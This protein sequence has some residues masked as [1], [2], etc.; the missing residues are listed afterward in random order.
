MAILCPT[1][2]FGI[3]FTGLC[4]TTLGFEHAGLFYTISAISM[5]AIRLA[6]KSFMDT[7]PVIKTYAVAVACALVEVW[8]AFGCSHGGGPLFLASGIIY[9]LALGIAMP[10]TKSVAIK[11]TP[12]ECWGA[13]SALFLLMNDLGIGVPSSLRGAFNDIWGFQAGTLCLVACQVSSFIAARILF[14]R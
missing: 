5:V 13:S 2:G 14:P 12:S 6:S 3:F 1:F 10:V 7:V 4:G 11:N 8:H 9:G